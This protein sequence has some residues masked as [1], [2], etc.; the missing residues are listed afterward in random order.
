MQLLQGPIKSTPSA[1]CSTGWTGPLQQ[2]G[3][4]L[5]DV[6]VVAL[7]KLAAPHML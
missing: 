3:H 7:I 4:L 2:A 6:V 1:G 5:L